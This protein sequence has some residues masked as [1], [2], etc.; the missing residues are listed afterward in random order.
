MYSEDIPLLHE[1]LRTYLRDMADE[2]GLLTNTFGNPAKRMEGWTIYKK[3]SKNFIDGI[4]EGTLAESNALGIILIS[5][6]IV[7][8]SN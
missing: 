1:K 7:H 6:I 8:V 2:G 5:S 4:G 3:S